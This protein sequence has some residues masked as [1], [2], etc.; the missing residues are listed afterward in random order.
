[1]AWAKW[2]TVI[3]P[4]MF[5][6]T[7]FTGDDTTANL[8]HAAALKASVPDP[9]KTAAAQVQVARGAAVPG[10]GRRRIARGGSA[11]LQGQG[12]GAGSGVA[13]LGGNRTL[14]GGGA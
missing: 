3:D 1:M 13:S 8:G 9:A 11:L 5:A 6:S 4:A 2:L 14:L 10:T 12:L 7:A